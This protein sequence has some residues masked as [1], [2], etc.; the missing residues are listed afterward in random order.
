MR[1]GH[2]LVLLAVLAVGYGLGARWPQWA[3][4]AG[5]AG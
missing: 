4:R 2:W 1:F 5:V 3:Q